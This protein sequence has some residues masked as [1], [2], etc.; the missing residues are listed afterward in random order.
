MKREDIKHPA[1]Y[2]DCLLPHFIEMLPQNAY[3]LDPF[4]GTG[5]IH[6]LQNKTVGLEIEPEWASMHKDTICG[7][8][9]KMPFD[10][11]IF[12]AVVTSPTYG[13]RMADHHNAKDASKRITYTHVLGRNLHENNSGKMHFGDKYKEL[14]QKVYVEC[15]RVLKNNGIFILNVKNFIKKGTEI[16]VHQWHCKTLNKLGFELLETR[17]VEVNGNGFGANRNKRVDYEYISKFQK[18]HITSLTGG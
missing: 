17:K 5:K 12:D 16:D 13:N 7:D 3:V 15:K 9:T 14:H 8:A 6:L 4:A 11:G 1:K 18:K 10:D 2:T